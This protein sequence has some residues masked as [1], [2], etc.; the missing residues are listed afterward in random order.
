MGRTSNN[1]ID[2]R[3]ARATLLTSAHIA[4]TNNPHN[5]A[6]NDVGLGN[7]N[8]TSDLDK[9][10]STA[11]QTA[12]NDKLEATDI[13]DKLDKNGYTGSV[14]VVESVDFV[15][16]TV[17]TKTITYVDGQITGVA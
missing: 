4:N 14:T 10:I 1:P 15:A 5:V 6:K 16:E 17:V 3:S 11:V 2:V 9:P 7:A 13:V 8:N 12:L